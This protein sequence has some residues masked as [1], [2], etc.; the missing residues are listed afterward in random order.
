MTQEE[1]KFINLI[2]TICVIV[3]K[4]KHLDASFKSLKYYGI[5]KYEDS[6]CYKITLEHNRG[7]VVFYINEEAFTNWHYVPC[8]GQERFKPKDFNE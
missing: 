1:E 2:K 7:T 4:N 6:K 3:N 5:A 8:T